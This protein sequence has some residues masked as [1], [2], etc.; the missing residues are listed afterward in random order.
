MDHRVSYLLTTPILSSVFW[1]FNL[2]FFLNKRT[3]NRT[4]FLHLLFLLPH[5]FYSLHDLLESVPTHE[6]LSLFSTS[7]HSKSLLPQFSL[8][9]Y[10]I[11]LLAA[12]HIFLEDS[13]LLFSETKI[14]VGFSPI[15]SGHV[16]LIF[17][18]SLLP[19]SKFER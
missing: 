2:L 7:N 16:L 4:T 10:F 3:M 13:I 19:F 15:S 1:K 12:F 8:R 14:S 6:H 17:H 5:L 9:L 18:A 11:S